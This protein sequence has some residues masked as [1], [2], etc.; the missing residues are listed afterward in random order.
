MALLVFGSLAVAAMLPMYAMEAR[1]PRYVLGFALASAAAAA[2]GFA[3]E[4][5]PFAVIDTVWSLVAFQ[6]WRLLLRPVS[7]APS[8]PANPP[9][10]STCLRSLSQLTTEPHRPSPATWT[11]SPPNSANATWP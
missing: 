6:R 9:E 7:A 5:W 2:Y 1:S 10:A 8:F 11:L 4:A 3:R